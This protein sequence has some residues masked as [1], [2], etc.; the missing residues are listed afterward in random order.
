M[1]LHAHDVEKSLST[2]DVAHCKKPSCVLREA[3]SGRGRVEAQVGAVIAARLSTANCILSNARERTTTMAA[4]LLLS[5][6]R[7]GLGLSKGWGIRIGERPS[8]RS[9]CGRRS[10]KPTEGWCATFA[11]HYLWQSQHQ[12]KPPWKTGQVKQKCSNLGTWLASRILKGVPYL[13][14]IR[15]QKNI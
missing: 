9:K 13:W 1:T 14:S 15:W 8:I 11:L 6:E 12:I 5:W 2:N 7:A 10:Q 4:G 3:G